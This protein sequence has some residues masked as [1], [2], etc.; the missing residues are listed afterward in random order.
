MNRNLT[1]YGNKYFINKHNMEY[2][3]FF[4]NLANVVEKDYSP[5]P[6]K[7]DN[8]ID[9]ILRNIQNLN[10]EPMMN[11]KLYKLYLNPPFNPLTTEPSRPLD[12]IIYNSN[13]LD[14]NPPTLMNIPFGLASAPTLA[15][16][17]QWIE[18]IK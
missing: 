10:S 18:K 12:P 3:Y 2:Y 11:Q 6:L 1:H 16:G 8:N 7:L 9:K 17:L 14:Q 4:N 13:I 5:L 15:L